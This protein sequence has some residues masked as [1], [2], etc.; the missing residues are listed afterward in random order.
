[1]TSIEI[2]DRYKNE[3]TPEQYRQ[4][5]S[6]IGSFAIEGMDLDEENIKD[7]IRIDKGESVESLI[8]EKLIRLG[9]RWQTSRN[10][11]AF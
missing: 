3:I 9:L 5:L 7:L 11:I 1:M 8:N 6:I 2:L 10:L 4:N